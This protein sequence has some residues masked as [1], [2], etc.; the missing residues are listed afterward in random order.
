MDQKKFEEARALAQSVLER[1]SFADFARLFLA[2]EAS[3]MISIIQGDYADVTEDE[4]AKFVMV[5]SR[6][7]RAIKQQSSGGSGCGG[8]G[9]C[10]NHNQDDEDGDED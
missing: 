10:D 5:V 1:V 6:I 2:S 9:G 7:Q 4:M 8:C 3:F